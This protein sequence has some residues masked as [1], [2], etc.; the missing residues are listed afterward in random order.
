MYCSAHVLSVRDETGCIAP[1]SKRVIVGIAAER[2][3]DKSRLS[4][5]L[6]GRLLT[7]FIVASSRI[8]KKWLG[9]VEQKRKRLALSSSGDQGYRNLFRDLVA[10]LP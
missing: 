4:W 10:T 7:Y 2:K 8:A 5:R 1:G 9:F 3:R 6:H